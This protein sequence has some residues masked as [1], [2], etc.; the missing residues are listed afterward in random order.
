MPAPV[1]IGLIKG[2]VVPIQAADPLQL[3]PANEGKAPAAH[4]LLGVSTD[5]HFFRIAILTAQNAAGSN[6]QIVIPFDRTINL[7]AASGFFQLANAA[8]APLPKSNSIPVLATSGQQPPTIALT[9][10]GLLGH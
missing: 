5:A 10:S 1:A 6:Y 2:A 7:S 9:V 8:G 4:L 3:L